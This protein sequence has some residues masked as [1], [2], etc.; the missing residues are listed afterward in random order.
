MGRWYFRFPLDQL[1]RNIRVGLLRCGYFDETKLLFHQPPRDLIVLFVSP[2]Q[3]HPLVKK[4]RDPENLVKA[5]PCSEKLVGL[6]RSPF[7]G[8]LELSRHR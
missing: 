2:G 8:E 3:G 4:Y 5:I 1:I 6:P 7:V